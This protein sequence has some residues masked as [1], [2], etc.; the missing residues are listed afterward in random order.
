MITIK[1]S[2]SKLLFRVA[3]TVTAAVLFSLNS[4]H[5]QK[6]SEIYPRGSK[7]LIGLYDAQPGID[8]LQKQGWNLAQSYGPNPWFKDMAKSTGIPTMSIYDLPGDLNKRQPPSTSSIV[9]WMNSQKYRNPYAWEFPEELNPYTTNETA[10]LKKFSD[11]VQQYDTQRRPRFMY[12]PSHVN[13]ARIKKTVPYLDL[14]GMSVYRYGSRPPAWIRWRMETTIKAI[15][16]SGRSVGPNYRGVQKTPIAVME[17]FRYYSFQIPATY[18]QAIHDIWAALVA[19]ARGIMIFSHSRINDDSRLKET[20]RGYRKAVDDLLAHDLD[21][22]LLWGSQE[23]SANIRV[24]SGPAY[25]DYFYTYPSKTEK[26]RLPSV[27]MREIDHG[28]YKYL[29]LVNSNQNGVVVEISNLKNA[30]NYGEIL[31]S[32]TTH[33]INSNRMFR[34]LNPYEAMVIKIKL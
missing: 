23:D 29:F 21:T 7:M 5:A 11:V 18:D 8:T 1:R 34:W 14:V 4:A 3:L 9:N 2:S 28:G 13:E 6:A 27:G 17:L 10:V 30:L 31:F 33:S 32:N 25:T 12:V 15:Y 26:I 24:V 16:D 19:G 20:W 22:V